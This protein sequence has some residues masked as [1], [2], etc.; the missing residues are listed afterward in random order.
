MDIYTYTYECRLLLEQAWM[1]SLFN[2]VLLPPFKSGLLENP[3]PETKIKVH[4]ITAICHREVLTKR[5]VAKKWP[6]A[7]LVFASLPAPPHSTRNRHCDKKEQKKRK[8]YH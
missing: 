4:Q 2:H 3:T 6:V 8:T 7:R 1:K 5:V